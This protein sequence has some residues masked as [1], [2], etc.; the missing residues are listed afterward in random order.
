MRAR[1]RGLFDVLGV[2]AGDFDVA[3]V[4]AVGALDELEA[5]DLLGQLAD[6]SMLEVDSAQDRCRLLETLGQYAWGRLVATE[7]LATARDRHG[8]Y[9]ATLAGEQARLMAAPGR[10]VAALDRLELDDDNLRAA[11]AHLIEQRRAEGAARMARRLIGLFNIRHP[12]EGL[13]WFRQVVDIADDLPPK[14]RARLPADAAWAALNAGDREAEAHFAQAAVDTGGEDAPAIAHW[15][16]AREEV[17]KGH[18]AVEHARLAV[19][20]A[21]NDLTTQVTATG[22]LA[23]ALA[24]A[25]ARARGSA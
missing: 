25:G 16:I 2:F 7:R 6:R 19:A 4:A 9:Y 1:C 10:Q 24:L 5:L 15:I 12:R 17:L 8:D 14:A 22:T 13:G 20:V 21:A 11:L 23:Q 18:P 3:A